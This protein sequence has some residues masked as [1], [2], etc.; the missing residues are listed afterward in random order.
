[1]NIIPLSERPIKIKTHVVDQKEYLKIYSVNIRVK[2][3]GHYNYF[4]SMMQKKEKK[5]PLGF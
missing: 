3:N 1:V 5:C 4:R 2:F